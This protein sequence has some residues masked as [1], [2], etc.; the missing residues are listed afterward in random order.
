M[1]HAMRPALVLGASAAILSLGLSGCSVL[2]AITNR[3]HS[4]NLKVGQ[5]I[6][7]PDG[8]TVY[9][10]EL[11]DC[12]KEHTGEVYYIEKITDATLPDQDEMDQMMEDACFDNF[13][14]YVGKSY[15]ESSLEVTA[16]YPTEQTWA[17]GDRDIVC[18]AL[19]G[20]STTLSRSVKDSNK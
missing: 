13:K 7:V 17:K 1:S 3:T 11:R 20:D 8:S 9:D 10:V 19:P 6:Q 4:T 2:S 5:C 12:S 16:M 15:S 14:S 18:V